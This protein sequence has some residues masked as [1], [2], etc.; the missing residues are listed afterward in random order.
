MW[1]KIYN[2][3]SSDYR[4][5]VVN[6]PCHIYCYQMGVCFLRGEGKRQMQ[7]DSWLVAHSSWLSP[8]C[9]YGDTSGYGLAVDMCQADKWDWYCVIDHPHNINT[10]IEN[11]VNLWTLHTTHCDS[12]R[13][14]AA[15]VNCQTPC[16]TLWILRWSL[17]SPDAVDETWNHSYKPEIMRLSSEWHHQGSP[18]PRK[19]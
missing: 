1:T 7:T 13:Q 4:K 12:D 10:E 8:H 2:N 9:L 16:E 14:M 18:H 15:Y 11:V 6:K 17:S 3:I 5:L 19:C